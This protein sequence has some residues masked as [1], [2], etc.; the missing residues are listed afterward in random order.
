LINDK[1]EKT[2]RLHDAKATGAQTEASSGYCCHEG[3]EI[4]APSIRV[5]PADG[6]A[7]PTGSAREGGNAR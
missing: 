1:S 7:E 4:K 6:A 2:W 5:G 3:P